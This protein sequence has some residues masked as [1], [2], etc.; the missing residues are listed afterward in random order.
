MPKIKIVVW[1]NIGNV[2]LGVRP[3]EEWSPRILS[4]LAGTQSGAAEQAPSV[5]EIFRDYDIELA[6]LYDPVKSQLG[7][8]ELYALNAPILR[9][10]TDPAT[11]AETIRDAD[12]LILHKEAV[13]PEVLH[14]A[15]QLRL[16]EHLGQDIRGIP[17]DVA[18]E[19][20]VP[21]AAI[22]L[23]NYLVVAEHSWA[24]ILNHLKQLPQQRA[25]MASRA[26]ADSWGYAPNLRYVADLTLGLL[27]LGEIARPLARFARAFDMRVRYWD[28][29]RFPE[30]EAQYGLEST[31]WDDLFRES[32]VLSVQLA[33][34]PQTQGIIGAREIGLLKPT[35]LFVNT[36]RGK[37]VDQAALTA[38][39]R[40]RRI[41]GAA[42]EVFA[43]EPLPA[44]DPLLDLHDDLSYNV[45]LTPHSS[46]IAPW[47]WLR[48]SQAVW[49][50]V[51]RSLKGEKLEWLV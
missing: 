27:G 15:T 46:S 50:N 39:L 51:L 5:A 48:D 12:Y 21:V 2:L 17:L 10:S 11:V 6:W 34:N 1:D 49:Y 38:A 8:R 19:M 29:V 18:R 24:L 28:R 31:E 23:T 30:L 4:R 7:F 26:Y 25:L 9:D 45:T 43:E 16:I 36:A 42:L 47:T 20:G 22:P 40:E 32:D 33:L 13:A 3:R 14:A 37:L 35:A 44:D 41:G